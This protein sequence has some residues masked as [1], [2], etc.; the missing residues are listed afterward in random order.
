M[1]E[2]IVQSACTK[3]RSA[4]GDPAMERWELTSDLQEMLQMLETEIFPFLGQAEKLAARQTTAASLTD[5]VMLVRKR[6]YGISD[7]LDE[8]EDIRRASPAAAKVTII[9]SCF[10]AD[11]RKNPMTD[12]MK[13]RIEELRG[14]IELK[15]KNSAFN[16]SDS[17]DDEKWIKPGWLP[18]DEMCWTIIKETSGFEGKTESDKEHLEKIGREIAKQCE[19]E[20]FEAKVLGAMLRYNDATGWEEALRRDLCKFSEGSSTPSY[21]KTAYIIMP[22]SLRLCYAYCALFPKGHIV[23]KE[24]LIRQWIALRLIEPQ[25]SDNSSL[26]Q[27]AEGYIRSLLDMSVL[28]V[29]KPALASENDYK[30]AVFLTI[31]DVN[32]PVERPYVG[33]G[34]HD[35]FIIVQGRPETYHPDYGR[36]AVLNKFDVWPLGWNTVLLPQL[37]ALHCIGCKEVSDELI[38]SARWLRVLEITGHNMQKLPETVCQLRHLG[39][40]SLSGCTGLITLPDSFED[41]SNLVY[42]DLSRCSK[43]QSLPKSLGKLTDLEYIDL[44]GCSALVS[45]PKSFGKLI[46]L[47]HVNL[48]G[49]SGL[50]TL[51][52]A[53]GNLI[54]LSHINLSGCSGLATLPESFGSLTKLERLDLSG[55]SGLLNLPRSLGN[56]TSLLHLDLSRCNALVNLPQSFCNL[57]KLQHLD[58][59]FWSSFEVIRTALGVTGLRHLNLSHPCSSVAEHKPL[60]LEGLKEALQKLN[61]LQ[62][63]NLSMFSHSQSEE[64]IGQYLENISVLGSLEHLDLSHNMYLRNV[65]EC[66]AG[67][68]KLHTLDLSGCIR[69]KTLP[70]KIY[71]MECLKLIALKHCRSLESYHF[72]VG[73][74]D[75]SVQLEDVNCRDMEIRCLEKVKSVEEAQSIRLREK[76]CLVKLKLCWTPLSQELLDANVLLGELVPPHGLQCLLIHGYGSSE[77]SRSPMAWWRPSICAD[78]SYLAEVTLEDMRQCTQLPPLGLLP[79]LQRLV[80]RKMASITRIDGCDLS[81]GNWQASKRLSELTI[82]D[83]PE[84]EAFNT[85]YEGAGGKELMFPAIDILVIRKC[86]KLEFVPLP[87]RARRLEVQEGCNKLMMASELSGGGRCAEGPASCIAAAPVTELVVESSRLDLADWSLLH[88]LPGLHSLTINKYS[89]QNIKNFRR[90]QIRFPPEALSSLQILCFSSRNEMWSLPQNLG[91]LTSLRELRI[92]CA[93]WMPFP[94]SMKQLT[95]LKS[96]HLSDCGFKKL[97]EWL[98]DLI[99]LEVLTIHKCADLECFPESICKLIN[100]KDLHVSKCYRLKN[101]CESEQNKKVLSRISPKYEQFVAPDPGKQSEQSDDTKG[102]TSNTGSSNGGGGDGSSEL[103]EAQPSQRPNSPPRSPQWDIYLT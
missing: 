47:V 4:I 97:P 50:V 17:D 96:M 74:R 39:C 103:S 92:S 64:E 24:C 91:D 65:P 27:L 36:Y 29:V 79:N 62:H 15:P 52:Q 26:T 89:F 46:N 8:L 85:R 7:M 82:D 59:S 6:A 55:C 87:P 99:S 3:L 56:L 19:G 34:L 13:E 60:R 70:E 48:S 77:L 57:E 30:G 67:L 69:L 22:S 44:S 21:L 102:S 93:R 90:T 33:S 14:T 16:S 45:L 80:L 37:R 98:G 53:I 66:L 12:K 28:Q 23:G 25:P 18:R 43:L 51:L 38:S 20:Q 35:E 42:I 54:M 40:L 100:L 1:A 32:F 11:R 78:L 2:A 75:N 73:A 49:C 58:L 9:L 63:L 86:P 88:H 94:E 41:L 83:M 61:K 81:F 72:V 76:E 5:W 84:L 10:A 95:S 31:H 101:W 71:E 68:N